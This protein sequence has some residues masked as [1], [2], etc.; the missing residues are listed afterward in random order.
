M[1]DFTYLESDPTVE[2]L[3]LHVA[4]CSYCGDTPQ[5]LAQ[6][7]DGVSVESVDCPLARAFGDTAPLATFEAAAEAGHETRWQA[8]LVEIY[9]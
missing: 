8:H 2:Q 4:F 3:L 6:L 1:S 7:D 5:C 9:S